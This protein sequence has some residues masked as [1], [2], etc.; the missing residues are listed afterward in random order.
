MHKKFSKIILRVSFSL[1]ASIAL[2]AGL[3]MSST[4]EAKPLRF[5][6]LQGYLS[7]SLSNHT[8]VRKFLEIAA[9]N[10]DAKLFWGCFDAGHIQHPHDTKEH[11]YLSTMDASGNWSPREELDPLTAP[12]EIAMRVSGQVKDIAS[13]YSEPTD[14][15]VMDVFIAGHSHGGWMAMRVAYHLS[16]VK[17]LEIKELLTIDP[18][19][20]NLCASK[21]FPVHVIV[22]TLRWWGEPHDCHRAPRDLE[23]IEARIAKAT[24][25]NWTNIYEESMP[26]LSSGPI[27]HATR[28]LSYPAHTTFDWLTAHRATLL[29]S[30]SWT[31]FFKRIDDV[32]NGTEPMVEDAPGE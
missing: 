14:E 13:T 6:Y 30:R 1:A 26:Y 15:P 8:P 27:R 32:V 12:Q 25:G 4:S 16:Y 19:S 9:T 31:R 28:N 3:L 20:Y 23:P 11:F 18:V 29:D 17:N 7:C 24:N 22:N 21:W 2:T 5:L 10:P